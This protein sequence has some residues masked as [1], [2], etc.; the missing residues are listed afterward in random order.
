MVNIPIAASIRFSDLLADWD[1]ACLGVRVGGIADW[2]VV[3]K[4]L[5]L[6]LNLSK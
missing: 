4:R 6:Y 3:P 1:E 2:R 5:L